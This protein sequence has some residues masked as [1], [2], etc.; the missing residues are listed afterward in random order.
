MLLHI[1]HSLWVTYTRDI[2]LCFCMNATHRGWH[3]LEGQWGAC[4]HMSLVMGGMYWSHQGD[5]LLHV[6]HSPWVTMG[7]THWSRDS[8][9]LLHVCHLSWVAHIGGLLGCLCAHVTRHGWHVLESPRWYDFACV[10]FIVGGTH[11]SH[12]ARRRANL[13]F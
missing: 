5:T 4:A 13:R 9:M 10:T 3:T 11:W 2:R 6:C 1:C 12:N 8:N 7:D